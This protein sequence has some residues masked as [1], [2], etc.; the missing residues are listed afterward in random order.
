MTAT[1]KKK[2]IW[3]LLLVANLAF[4]WGN[5]LMDGSQSGQ[6]SGGILAWI[7][8]FLGLEEAGAEFLH[9]LIRKAAHF[10]EFACLGALLTWGCGMAGHIGVSLYTLPLFG[11]LTAACIDETIQIYVAGRG[12]SLLDVW[13]DAAG[14][15]TGMMLLLLGHHLCK[16]YK[17]E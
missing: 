3:V 7:N 16:K 13:T 15:L 6:L 8:S 4:I 9:H 14:A 1:R 17:Q 2:W 10:T 11:S 12:S 5:S